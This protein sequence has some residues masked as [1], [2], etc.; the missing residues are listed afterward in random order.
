MSAQR[1][2]DLRTL[3]AR[4]AGTK[5]RVALLV[6]DEAL[7]RALEANG[8]TVLV[9]PEDHQALRG[10]RPD[11][12]V[13]LDGLLTSGEE[14]LRSLATEL[15]GVELL[16]SFA[17]A[18][19]ASTLLRGLLGGSLPMASSERDVQAWLHAAGFVVEARDVVV[20]PHEPL[21]LSA[22]T[23][24]A[25]R[26]LLEQ[27]N[28]DAAADRVLLVAS[29][30]V[31]DG[32]AVHEDG[33]T[34]VVISAGDDVGAL[35]GTLRTVAN[36]LQTPL[37]LIVVSELSAAQLDDLLRSH[38]TRFTLTVLVPEAPTDAMARTNF[39]IKRARGQYLCALEA[40]ELLDRSH[41]S[42]LVT[43]LKDGTEAWALSSAPGASAE[44]FDLRAWLEAGA[45]HRGRYVL[46]R[47]R[48]GTFS[49]QFP[50]GLEHGEAALFCRLAALFTP[51]WTREAPT[52]DSA[53]VIPDA[54][55]ALA[56][57]WAARPLQTLRPLSDQLAPARPVSLGA[58]LEDRLG[59]QS[60]IAGELFGQARELWAKVRTA[61][62]QA[63]RDA[64]RELDP[65]KP[66]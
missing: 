26:Q 12:V 65:K 53:R 20:T 66:E 42:R 17:T 11:V 45:V 14:G 22:D 19:S 27:L 15:P 51:A 60:P 2:G 8:C 35:E 63:K 30:G 54:T 56:E 55:Q 3:L 9:D 59:A 41:L 58:I 39:G 6:A 13:A 47:Q 61:A 18:S 4:R 1:V 34:S 10:F 5:R 49:L 21:P 44:R 38:R 50:E 25:F 48:L 32:P 23:E 40:G 62:T 16:L 24:A 57:A 43:R 29:A 52:L 31:G 28:P 37:E 36:Q 64:E 7:Q 33:L 46:D